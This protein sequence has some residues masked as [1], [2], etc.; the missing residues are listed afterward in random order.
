MAPLFLG[1]SFSIGIIYLSIRTAR[2]VVSMK[3]LNTVM[4]SGDGMERVAEIS[5][6]RRIDRPMTGRET[7]D[8]MVRL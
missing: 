1:N 2:M 5:L 7:C 4:F 8:R 6:L 3:G